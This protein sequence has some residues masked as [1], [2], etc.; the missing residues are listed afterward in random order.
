MVSG[1]NLGSSSTRSSWKARARGKR[2]KN[3]AGSLSI[4]SPEYRHLSGVEIRGS[5]NGF[6]RARRAGN[7][8]GASLQLVIEIFQEILYGAAKPCVSGYFPFYSPPIA[9]T[10]FFLE[11]PDVPFASQG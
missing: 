10:W 8:H 6:S 11:K 3:E 7:P 4:I 9:Q 1:V 2:E 5:Q